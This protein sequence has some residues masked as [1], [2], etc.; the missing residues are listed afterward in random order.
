MC[1]IELV[2]I[3]R[4]DQTGLDA[5]QRVAP[6]RDEVLTLRPTPAQEVFSSYATR[7]LPEADADPQRTP[8]AVLAAGS[9]VGFGVLDRGGALARVTDRSA[10]AVLL[11]AFY[12]DASVQGRGLGRAAVA[13]LPCLVGLVAPDATRILLTVN[14]AN[15]AAIRAYLAGGFTDTGRQHPGGPAGPQHVLELMLAQ[16]ASS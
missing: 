13:A 9:A 2:S 5:D 6:L 12:L 16:P 14:V 8:F 7:T 15:P 10:T 3:A 11:R 4:A 1:D